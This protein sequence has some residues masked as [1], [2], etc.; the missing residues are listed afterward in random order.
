FTPVTDHGAIAAACRDHYSFEGEMEIG[1][2]FEVAYSFAGILA[3]TRDRPKIS[4]KRKCKNHLR[5]RITRL[6]GSG[7]TIRA[8]LWRQSLDRHTT[9]SG[10]RSFH[11]RWVGWIFTITPRASQARRWL[12]K[13]CQTF[14]I[15]DRRTGLFPA[16]NWRC[17]PA[18]R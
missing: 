11:I 12:Q 4:S 5:M 6:P 14:L 2:D 18:I 3:D 1:C 17:S 8:R 16:M 15:K 13:N 9:Q 10:T 7:M